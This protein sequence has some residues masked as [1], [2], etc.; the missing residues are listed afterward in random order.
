MRVLI[1]GKIWPEPTSSAAGTRTL[2][3]I[4][5]ISQTNWEI[6]FACAAQVSDHSHDLGKDF[7]LTTHSIALNDSSFDTWVSKLAPQ[8]VIF[9]R[10]MTEEQYGWRVAQA[11]PDSLRV[12]DTSDLHCLRE[13]RHQS[14]KTGG[15]LNL[16][17]PIALREIA[18]LLRVD[19]CLIISEFEVQLL[20]QNFPIANSSLAY[21]PF[22]LPKP[23]SENLSY[24]NRSNFVMIGSFMHEPNWDAVQF[25]RHEI[26]P[27]IRHKLPQAEVDVYG[28][29]TP[30]KARQ[31]HNER[32]GFCISGR[33]PNAVETLSHYR[34]NLA[35]LRFGAGLKGKLADAF[36][37][38]TPSIASPIAVEGMCGD[39]EWGSRVSI[40]PGQFADTAVETYLNPTAWKYAQACGHEIAKKR[41]AE[42]IWLPK[43]PQILEQAHESM[44]TN[45]DKN[46]VGKLLNHHQHRST[47]FM[48]RWIEA[49]N[50]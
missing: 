32:L 10:F 20:E 41:F 24:D 39:L 19:L 16:H 13:A 23:N 26:W 8:I 42:E 2:D 43:L 46:F 17:N 36:L 1:L 34:V 7:E 31:L 38:G 30:D 18:S 3:L 44:H 9:D 48:S 11:L 27:I 25:C 12:I 14:L 5:S 47:E 4:R 28:S 45:R 29:Y 40:E 49:K 22:A 21:W 37:A 35:P 6:H 15:T 50:K 33:A